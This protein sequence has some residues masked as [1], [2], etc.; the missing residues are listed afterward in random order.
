MHIRYTRPLHHWNYFLSIESDL[1]LTSKY[2]ELDLENKKA[3]SVQFTKIIIEAC[4]EVDVL[5]SQIT[6]ILGQPKTKPNFGDHYTLIKA[7]AETLISESLEID[8]FGITLNPYEEWKDGNEPSWH[9]AY[10]NLKHHR[11]EFYKEGN[12]ENALLSVGA[13]FTSAIHFYQC[14]ASR[15]C[16]EQ[17]VQLSDVINSLEPKAK[18]IR[19]QDERHRLYI[20]N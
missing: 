6:R 14:S 17:C 19:Y 9:K 10:N 18:L 5:L 8:K 12:L 16:K 15:A 13:L 3:F 1:D 20:L 2:V 11:G 7:K 4:S